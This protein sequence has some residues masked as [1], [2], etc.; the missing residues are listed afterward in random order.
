MSKADHDLI[1]VGGG[2][3]GLTAGIYAARARMDVLLVEKTAPGGQILVSDHVENYPGFPDGIS[4]AE[5]AFLIQ[6]QA[7]KFGLKTDSGEIVY[8]DFSG[9]VKKLVMEG[10]TLTAKAVIIATGASPRK[11]G[12]PGEDKHYGRGVSF[13]ATCDA[14]FFRGK[15]VAAVGGGDT[16]IQESL[17]LAKFAEK[18]YVIHRRDALRAAKVIQERAFAE[19]KIEFVWDS[20]VTEVKGESEVEALSIKNVRTGATSDLAVSGCFVWV[21]ITPNTQFLSGVVDLDK[22]GFVIA[23]QRMETSV[24]GIFAVG[25]CR[26]TP[27]RQV[28]T[29]VGDAAIA[30]VSAEHYIESLT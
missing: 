6:R 15:V 12:V 26:N 17:F 16:A 2:P 19:P 9:P 21:G 14:P 7:E 22:G 1:I 28:A 29:A 30:A 27:L 5:L 24:A 13:C 4:G 3:A 18:V 23:D 11:L 20:V 25:D 10:R 8:A